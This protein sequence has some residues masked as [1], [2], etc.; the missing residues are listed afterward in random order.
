MSHLDLLW[1]K[2]CSKGLKR[3]HLMLQTQNSFGIWHFPAPPNT[4]KEWSAESWGSIIPI[5]RLHY[6]LFSVHVD[7]GLLWKSGK[8][9]ENSLQ[10]VWFPP[11][12]LRWPKRQKRKKKQKQEQHENP[13]PSQDA[14]PH[15]K[16]W[17]NPW[18]VQHCSNLTLSW[19][20]KVFCLMQD[21][22]AQSL[23]E[24]RRQ[25]E[26]ERGKNKGLGF[27]LCTTGLKGGMERF[28]VK[29]VPK[30]A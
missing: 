2:P 28:Y 3:L 10:L 20:S 26:G 5:L 29:E 19:A 27:S 13:R 4:L 25:S 14:A 8:E 6:S 21:W 9:F 15:T 17:E 16:P 12:P 1:G 18:W 7:L 30:A 23:Q 24:K 22:I 11:F